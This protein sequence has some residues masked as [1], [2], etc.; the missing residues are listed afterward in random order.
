MKLYSIYLKT[1][2]FFFL[3][4]VIIIIIRY[5]HQKIFYSY[6]MLHLLLLHDFLN[7]LLKMIRT[8]IISI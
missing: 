6:R 7:L 2:Y 1:S 5:Q 4:D 8:R 3:N